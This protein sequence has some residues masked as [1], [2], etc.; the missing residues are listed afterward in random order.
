MLRTLWLG[1][2]FVALFLGGLGA[3]LPMVPTTPFIIL[4]AACFARGSPRC[5]RWLREH[6]RFGQVL[7]EWEDHGAIRR[8]S[9]VWATALIA[10][11]GLVSAAMVP[12]AFARIGLATVLGAVLLFIWTRRE[13]PPPADGAPSAAGS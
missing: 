8:R 6:P 12:I 13:P 10:L 3:V 9:K 7:R 1:G 5:H 11:T 2:G 4:A